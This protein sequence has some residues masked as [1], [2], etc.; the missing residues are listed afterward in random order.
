[1]DIVAAAAATC[2]CKG[3]E[4]SLRE[5]TPNTVLISGAGARGVEAEYC[6]KCFKQCLCFN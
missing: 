4:N 5:Y 6:L 2:I 3:M 1:M